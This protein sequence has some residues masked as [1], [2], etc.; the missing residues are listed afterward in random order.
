MFR[1][2]LPSIL[3]IIIIFVSVSSLIPLSNATSPAVIQSACNSHSSPSISSLSVAF[4]STVT[5][6]DKLIVAIT[7][8]PGGS[9][10]FATITDSASNSYGSHQFDDYDAG[11]GLNSY[12]I[13]GTAASTVSG[14]TITA[15][16]SPAL[17]EINMC[18]FEIS[19]A[20]II[21]GNGSNWL[22]ASANPLVYHSPNIA[23][24]NGP[25][26]II[27][28]FN[29]GQFGTGCGSEGLFSSPY[30]SAGTG[31]LGTIN[32]G[33][34][35]YLDEFMGYA[36]SVSSSP[37]SFTYSNSINNPCNDYAPIF[38]YIVITGILSITVTETIVGWVFPNFIDGQNTFS[39]IY[40]LGI[41]L[42][43]VAFISELAYQDTRGGGINLD[44]KS[45]IFLTLICLFIGSIIG[46][47]VNL[48]PVLFPFL[49]GII[50][51]IYI[52]RGS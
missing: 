49:L 31:Q 50:L 35:T 42:F 29:A 41:M 27:A 14:L 38:S 20:N 25:A 12:F 48:I 13:I 2:L 36:S 17:S 40:I 43:P 34:N 32:I 18:A 39:W 5:K 28:N 4:S 23:F 7:S 45:P 37:S 26:I 15:S 52:W 47:F 19:N 30:V 6:N 8:E 11:H 1:Q 33:T 44:G 24:T 51:A 46:V 22:S 16:F 10:I 21:N 9:E 3:V